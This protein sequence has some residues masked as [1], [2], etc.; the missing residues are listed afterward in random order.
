MTIEELLTKKGYTAQ[1]ITDLKPLLSNPKFRSD[2]EAEL[3]DG[4]KAKSDLDAYDRWF[5]EEITPEHQKLME[6][7]AT[8]EA[9]AAAAKARFEA[10]Q[11]S[12]MRKQA[13]DQDPA[14][15]AAAAE[16]EAEKARK[17]ASGAGLDPS[18]FVTQETF[19][20]VADQTGDA[21]ANAIDIVTDH[22]QL[23]PGQQ[24]NMTQLRTEAKAARVPVRQ[25]WET[26]YKV[27]E[28]KAAIVEEAEKKKLDAAR[29]EGYQKAAVE[30][31]G[32]NPNL[33]VPMP[34]T[35]PFV[36]KKQN[37]DAKQPWER[38]ESELSRDRVEK[39]IQKAASRG[40]LNAV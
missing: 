40:E 28:R 5:T 34:S 19:L 6:R 25:Y 30:F 39:A 36:I 11:K 27:A 18:K 3:N 31:G 26:K 1:E 16:E 4:I 23:F 29:Q 32:N 2:L 24:L 12:G 10:Y 21:M 8:A 38:N 17:A 20:K 9:E 14:A 15:A 35:N 13:G 37:K 33:R 7:V 22:M